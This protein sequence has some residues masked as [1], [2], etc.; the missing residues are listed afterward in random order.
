[1]AEFDL[2]SLDGSNGFKLVGAPHSW[3]GRSTASAGD[4]N[5]DGFADLIIGAPY[6]SPHGTYSGAPYV[7]FG[8][9]SGVAA[10]IDLPGLDGNDGIELSGVAAG[11]YSGGSVASAGDVNGDGF[12]DM[13]IGARHADPNG[14]NSGASYVVF[15]FKPDAAVVRD[16]TAAANSIHG[17]DF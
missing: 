10:Q 8:K 1:D 5:G 4:V 17:G 16:G 14:D 13:V 6:D 9:A 7:V 11:D 3:S 15:G 12:D 2:A